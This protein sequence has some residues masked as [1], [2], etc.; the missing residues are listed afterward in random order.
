MRDEQELSARARATRESLLDAARAAF[1]EQGY[2]GT[3]VADVAARAGV[4][5]G[6]FYTYFDSRADVLA[7]LVDAVGD[8]LRGVLEREWVGG[9]PA[10]D[11]HAVVGE[12]V[13]A[14]A[15]A[16]DLVRVWGEAAVVEPA[17]AASRLELREQI[18]A[19]VAEVLRPALDGTPH[20]AG[21]V[22]VALTSMVEGAGEER[23]VGMDGDDREAALRT[24]SGL[25]Y[26]ALTGLGRA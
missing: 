18:V 24:L 9:A 14:Y 16:G 21:L 26:G 8:R 1:V 10:A 23:V 20:D 6:T 25:W 3:R 12:Y 15:D 7:A 19:R 11:V 5:H 2:A 13:A 17:L 22:A 4:A